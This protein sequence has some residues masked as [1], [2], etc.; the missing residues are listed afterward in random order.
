MSASGKIPSLT[1]GRS[2]KNTESRSRLTPADL[3]ELVQTVDEI[4]PGF[5]RRLREAYPLLRDKDIP[6]CCLLKCGITTKDLASI[7]YVTP[8]AISK[9]K[10]R[11]KQEQFGVSD[12]EITLEELLARF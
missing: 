3:E 5:S 8:S 4:W 2:D 12:E 1:G 9:K 11:M 7:Y 6:F 10:G